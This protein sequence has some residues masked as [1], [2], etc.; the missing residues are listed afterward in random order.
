MKRW[1]LILLSLTLI[2]CGRSSPVFEGPIPAGFRSVCGAASII[3]EP[4]P[5]IRSDQNR[6]CGIRN[7]VRL[8]AVAG[9]RVTGDAVMNCKTAKTLDGWVARTA[10]RAVSRRMDTELASLQVVASY[11]CRTRNSQR[12]AKLS[13]HAKG[14]AVDIGGFRTS[15]GQRVTLLK[16]WDKGDAGRA[17]RDMHRGACGPFGVVLGPEAN[18]FHRD[19]FH[20]DVSNFARAYCR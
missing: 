7:P 9:V 8:F 19:H 15:D 16:D 4:L 20:F 17:L 10:S 3:G 18:R 13:E 6:A 2:T 14:N 1:T 12:G 11:A 5:R